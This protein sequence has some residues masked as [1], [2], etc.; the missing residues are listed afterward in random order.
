MLKILSKNHL[1]IY[2]VPWPASG[3]SMQTAAMLNS[4]IEEEESSEMV[5]TSSHD[6]D[7]SML[8]TSTMEELAEAEV[9]GRYYG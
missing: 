8:D 7:T 5:D 3:A 2:S 9:R 4:S 1:T 6:V